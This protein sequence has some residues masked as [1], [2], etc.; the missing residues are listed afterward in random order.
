[1]L[2]TSSKLTSFVYIIKIHFFYRKKELVITEEVQEEET[3]NI[4]KREENI[5]TR[6]MKYSMWYRSQHSRYL[7]MHITHQVSLTVN[8]HS[9]IWMSH[10][11]DWLLTQDTTPNGMGDGVGGHH[12]QDLVPLRDTGN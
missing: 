11:E 9:K 5:N 12:V 7:K 4:T 10:P 6:K 2:Q 8:E 1:M 3:V